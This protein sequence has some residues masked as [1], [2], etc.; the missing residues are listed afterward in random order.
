MAKLKLIVIGNGMAG[1]KCIEEIISIAPDLYNITVFGSEPYPNYNRIM[2]SKVLQ[3]NSALDDIIINSWEWYKEKGILLYAGTLVSRIDTLNKYVETSE[4][5]RVE[6]DRLILAT[7][8]TAYIPNLPGVNKEGITGFRTIEDCL[9]MI[10][11]AKSYKRAAVI[12]G[13]LLGLEA[14]KGLL[15][16]GMDVHVVHNASFIM[17]RQLDQ[18]AAGLLR[19][20]LES[21][22]MRFLLEKRTEKILGRR[23]AKGLLFDDGTQLE[24]DFIVFAVGIRPRVELAKGSGI[25]TNH[26]FV[27]DDYMQTNIQDVYAVGECAE[28]EGIVYGL[29]APLYEQGKVLARKLC[30]VN[31]EP[32]RGSVPSAQLK[33]SGIEVFSAGKVYDAAQE[34]A[35]QIY[36]GVTGA[37]KKVTMSNGKITGA[38]LY[39]DNSE[40][41]HLLNLIKKQ[42]PVSELKQEKELNSNYD[43]AIPLKPADTVCSCNNVCK[44]VIVEA[45]LNQGLE[46]VDQVRSETKASQS[47]GGCRPLV[48]AVIR[49]ALQ[50]PDL[51]SEAEEPICGCTLIGHQQLINEIISESALEVENVISRLNWNNEKGCH[52][53]RS[54]IFYYLNVHGKYKYDINQSQLLEENKQFRSFNIH[55]SYDV[56]IKP[57]EKV[58]AVQWLEKELN[59]AL[60][61]LMLPSCVTFAISSG[62]LYPAGIWVNSFGV[63]ATPAGWEIYIGGHG[64]LPLRQGSPLSIES[65]VEEALEMLICTVQWYRLSAYYGEQVWEWVERMNIINI[66]EK[67]F[68]PES[69]EKLLLKL[70]EQQT[71]FILS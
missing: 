37:Y 46:T 27:V 67:L 19:K 36:D 55:T 60:D 42:S 21:Q 3:G 63:T 18:M 26:A 17:N 62:T 8:S 45:V 4:G 38:I 56:S 9:R 7:G 39:G 44:S 23:R 29:V 53:C 57:N 64:E 71:G 69:R 58:I 12:G 15:N 35:L 48:E 5:S 25:H 1:I 22:G 14:A 66:R 33:V 30:G 20:E 32:Y 68:C 34:T 61:F 65:T 54:S 49:Q 59:Q 16:L 28:H 43:A 50:S 31:S 10:E 52:V 2:L 47:C 70:K 24:V 6:Y 41:G 13:G 11:V 40:A 51:V